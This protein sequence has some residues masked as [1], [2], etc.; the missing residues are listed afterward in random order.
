MSNLIHGFS[1]YK[2]LSAFFQ[3][4]SQE[5]KSKGQCNLGGNALLELFCKLDGSSNRRT[6]KNIFKYKYKDIN[7]Y[8]DLNKLIADNNY[9]FTILD[10]Y[11][12]NKSDESFSILEEDN[13]NESHECFYISTPIGDILFGEVEKAKYFSKHIE[14]KGKK[15]F[16][17]IDE[18]PMVDEECELIKK[19][20]YTTDCFSSAI[21]IVRSLVD[22]TLN[23]NYLNEIDD[24]HFLQLIRCD[25]DILELM[26]KHW[27]K[28]KG[29]P[30]KD[31]EIIPL[32]KKVLTFNREI[33]VEIFIEIRKYL[34]QHLFF[35]IVGYNT[36]KDFKNNSHDN[37][38]KLADDFYFYFEAL[39]YITP[40]LF[41]TYDCFYI[42]SHDLQVSELITKEN[43][44]E[45]I[46]NK[47]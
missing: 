5:M 12:E 9:D 13:Y 18:N 25:D 43:Y 7:S 21:K 2:S 28:T 6:I 39:D 30:F 15:Y 27:K 32:I 26:L 3:K 47:Y 14:T 22:S 41:I 42:Q 46:K 33:P 40:Q 20:T 44:D 10:T 16:I 4:A 8:E 24:L 17:T 35:S 38:Y 11:F 31:N 34:N 29:T 1:D 45:K 23:E 19:K 37:S 36:V